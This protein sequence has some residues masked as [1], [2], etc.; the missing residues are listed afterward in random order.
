MKEIWENKRYR[1]M[2][3]LGLWGFFIIF[4]FV[5][6]AFGNNNQKVTEE[7]KKEKEIT[8]QDLLNAYKNPLNTINYEI[9]ITENDTKIILE[10]TY[11]L[12]KH[13]GYLTTATEVISYRCENRL[14][15]KTFIDHEEPM[16]TY[17][18]E[19]IKDPLYIAKF[20]DNLVLQDENED[21]K[22]YKYTEIT[23]DGTTEYEVIT[24]KQTINNEETYQISQI[25][26]TTPNL[27]IETKVNL[28]LGQVNVDEN[29]N[30]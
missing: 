7:P 9:T 11:V 14:C 5:L 18:F 10:G 21:K 23:S 15:Y 30:Q 29:N 8:I 4:I 17:L 2:I 28:E 1:S 6:A 12:N 19:G 22:S 24:E 3:V 16:D 13:T 26:I 20:A 27:R 25:N